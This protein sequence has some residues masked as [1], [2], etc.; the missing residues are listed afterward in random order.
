MTCPITFAEQNM[1]TVIVMLML[2]MMRMM[3]MTI[4]QLGQL[5]ITER[6][7]VMVTATVNIFVASPIAH[8]NI[9]NPSPQAYIAFVITIFTIFVRGATIT[10]IIMHD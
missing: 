10:T 4:V 5:S 3:N 9:I 8:P 7:M 2:A 1:P 6:L